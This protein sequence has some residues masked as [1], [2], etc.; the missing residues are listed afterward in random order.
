MRLALAAAVIS[1][2][3]TSLVQA[4]PVHYDEAIDGDLGIIVGQGWSVT[5]EVA[6]GINTV[7]G[8]LGFDGTD[9]DVDPFNLIVPDDTQIESINFEYTTTILANP[10]NATYTFYLDGT[11]VII[12]NLP[13]RETVQ[14]TQI[15]HDSR[16]FY[17]DL[18]PIG[19]GAYALGRPGSS[20]TSIMIFEVAYTW[21]IVVSGDEPPPPITEVFVPY[22]RVGPQLDGQISIDEWRSA[23]QIPFENGSISVVHDLTHLYFLFNMREDRSDNAFRD[24]GPDQVWLLADVDE[25][26]AVTPNVDLRYRMLSGTGNFRHETYAPPGSWPFN[27]PA[28]RSFSTLAE[29]FGCFFADGSLTATPFLNCDRHRVWEIGIDL[30]EARASVDKSIRIGLL[31]QSEL[32]EVESLPQDLADFMQFVHFQLEGETASTKSVGTTPDTTLSIFD[33]RV[34]QGV[35]NASNTIDLVAGRDTW[36]DVMTSTPSRADAS[37]VTVFATQDGIDLPGSPFEK[38]VS[39]GYYSDREPASQGRWRMRIDAAHTQ[40]DINFAFVARQPRLLST[41]TGPD[42]TISFV[43]TVTPTYWITPVNTGSNSTVLPSNAFLN[44]QELETRVALPVADIDFV[45]RPAFKANPATKEDANALVNQFVQQAA[46]G[47]TM[48]LLLTGESPFALPDQIIGAFSAS[49]DFGTTIGR[50]DP[51]WLDGA[52]LGVWIKDVDVEAGLLLAHE[53]NHNFDLDIAGTWGRH[54]PG[55]GANG[56]DPQWPYVNEQIQEP[57]LL[58]EPV[59]GRTGFTIMPAIGIDAD[60]P[61]YM[62]YCRAGYDSRVESQRAY[63]YQWMSPYRWRTQ[64]NNVFAAAPAT[65]SFAATAYKSTATPAIR[66]ALYLSGRVRSDG[67]GELGPVLRQPGITSAARRPGDYEIRLADCQGTTVGTKSFGASFIDVEGES[68]D[69]VAFAMT[70]ADPGTLCAVQLR[71]GGTLLAEQVVTA[72]VPEVAIASPNGGEYWDGIVT[73]GWTATDAD[74]DEL[75]A[76]LFYSPDAGTR[77]LPVAGGVTGREFTFDSA[78]LPGSEQAL[79]RV[80]VTDGINTT[81]DDSNVVFGV[82]PKAPA[83]HIVGPNA[84]GAIFAGEMQRFRGVA[85]DAQGNVLPGDDFI[86]LLNGAAVGAGETLE[87]VLPPGT[88]QL[89]LRVVAANGQIGETVLELGVLDYDVDRDLVPDSVDACPL[90]DTSS[91]IHFDGCV[92]EVYN[93]VTPNGCKVTDLLEQSFAESG[94]LGAM[95]EARRLRSEGLLT[96]RDWLPVHLCVVRGSR[97]GP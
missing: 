2:S 10:G 13:P 7:T 93:L 92:T 75:T 56:V 25:D 52:A 60:I 81:R 31:V 57:A 77:W 4:E 55:C 44:R 47:W 61:D 45:R 59:I 23:P 5:I 80:I 67:S 26:G 46:L 22:Q 18:I 24:G 32:N 96:Q 64:L 84:S 69:E 37:I 8:V 54:A 16:E 66:D 15:P 83:V 1:M 36:V 11:D 38:Y 79:M 72:N 21:T 90:S 85:R 91:T 74:D 94:R 70:L 14:V 40:Q 89:V 29:G 97:G 88:S 27:P 63:P 35:Q 9:A 12:D 95:A 19:P 49:K 34:T 53:L 87:L 62:T 3:L 68:R 78:S 30:L 58:T 73:V 42:R 41:T 6:P 39:E 82:A 71:R 48:G 86:W 43:E 33:V 20:R 51:R 17:A 50:S 76:S 65:A 28:A